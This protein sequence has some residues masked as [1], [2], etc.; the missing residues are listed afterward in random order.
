VKTVA[1]Q[2]LVPLRALFEELSRS[3]Q[4]RMSVLEEQARE[5]Q[6]SSTQL[7]AASQEARQTSRDA[8]E[9]LESLSQQ[10]ADLRV[11]K[12]RLE[13]QVQSAVNVIVK[14]CNT[15]LEF[16]LGLPELENR[17]QVEEEAQRLS[18]RIANLGAIKPEAASEFSTLKERYD[19]LMQK[20]GD[21][22]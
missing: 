6:D 9:R 20:V 5:A 3:A 8:H 14:D 10:L 7:Q 22:E 13:L 16:A 2:R 1:I 17:P 12:G 21:L 11:E 18:K 15:P 19:Y 4:R